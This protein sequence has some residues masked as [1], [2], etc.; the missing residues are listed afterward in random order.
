MVFGGDRTKFGLFL[1][2]Y[3][4]LSGYIDGQDFPLALDLEDV[5]QVGSK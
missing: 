3:M 4:K 1:R 2:S 5:Q